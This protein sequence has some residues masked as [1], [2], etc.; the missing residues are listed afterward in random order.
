MKAMK[1]GMALVAG[2]V[3]ATSLAACGDDGGSEG[4]AGTKQ[5]T[6]ATQ[7]DFFGVPLYIAVEKGFFEEQGLDAKLQEFPTGVEGTE[8]V[9]TGQADMTTVAGFPVASLAAQG[10]PVKVI[11]AN[12]TSNDWWGIAATKDIQEP[13]DLYGKKIAFQSNSTANYWFDRFVEQHDLDADRIEVV[14][15]K[16]AQLVALFAKGDVDAI[17]HFEPNVT[18][19]VGSRD[20]AHV[21]WVGGDDGLNPLIGYVVAGSAIS[22]DEDTGVKVLK[23]LQAAADWMNEN[24]DEVAELAMAKTGISDA[25]QVA[26]IMDKIEFRVGFD[27]ESLAQLQQIADYMLDKG[28]IEEPVDAA[29]YAEPDW[30]AAAA[31]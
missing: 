26:E 15:A 23:A 24:P 9:V 5:V 31:N 30:A 21:A 2:L 28:L 18:Q 6:V 10:A 16:F 25:A 17:I 22:E 13:E 12:A 14:D 8:A 1:K 7:P 11:G 19:A 29:G 3:L 4:E 27:D 20:G